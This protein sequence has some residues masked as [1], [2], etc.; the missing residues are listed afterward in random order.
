MKYVNEVFSDRDVQLDGHEYEGCRFERVRFVYSGIGQLRFAGNFVDKDCRWSFDGPAANTVT[1]MA[2]AYNGLGEPGRYLIDKTFDDI[3]GGKLDRLG[4]AEPAIPYKPTIFIG[5]GAS[6]DYVFLENFLRGRGYETETFES[7]PRA[8]KVTK[9]VVEGMSRRAAMAFLIHTSEDEQADG[10]VRA[11][12]NVVHET[13]LFQG[14][15]GFERAIVL[16][17]EGCESFSNMDGV[18]E[19]RYKSGGIKDI[20]LEVLDTVTREFPS[21]A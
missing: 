5:H 2:A 11:R 6:P 13:G 4:D 10:D 7:G 16:R 21:A 1:F 14:R 19:I 17:E 12:Q 3:R 20:F 8:G 9:D 15:L 18:Q